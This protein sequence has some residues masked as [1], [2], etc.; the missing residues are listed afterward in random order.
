MFITFEGGEG[1]GKTTQIKRLERHLSD[2]GREVICLREP[3]GSRGAETIRNLVLNGAIDRWS[4][5][6]ELFLFSAARHELVRTKII[7]ALDKGLVVLCDRYADSSAVYQGRAGGVPQTALHV[8]ENLATQGL[9]PDLTFLIDI[10]VEI[11]LTRAHKR[12]ADLK[13]KQNEGRFEGKT[14][15]FHED[16]RHAFLGRAAQFPHRFRV[17][18]GAQG[19]EEIGADIWGEV[20]EFCMGQGGQP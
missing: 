20:Q 18:N 1:A 5:V 19:I 6:E 8:I 17:I 11:G 16:V 9:Q 10:P 12:I 2:Q 15:K 7:P 4:A 3:G 14:F 13:F